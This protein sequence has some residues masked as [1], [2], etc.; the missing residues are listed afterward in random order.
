MILQYDGQNFGCSWYWSIGLN[1][2]TSRNDNKKISTREDL[3][4]A[5]NAH[6]LQSAKSIVAEDT[7]RVSEKVPRKA[8]MLFIDWFVPAYKAGGPI[9][10]IAN[11]VRNMSD[12]YAFYVVCGAKDLGE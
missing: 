9:R 2:I 1:E 5:P 10:S 3:N 4:H 11:M 6:T 12:E 7:K 8:V